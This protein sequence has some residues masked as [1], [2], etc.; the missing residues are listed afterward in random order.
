MYSWEALGDF[1]YAPCFGFIYLLWLFPM[2]KLYNSSHWKYITCILNA[3]IS[4]NIFI[5]SQWQLL[6]SASMLITLDS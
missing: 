2:Y 5:Q 4:K 1:A 6:S 3:V